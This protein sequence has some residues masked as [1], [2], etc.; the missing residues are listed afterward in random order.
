MHCKKNKERG[1]S[2]V[3]HS[4][5]RVQ[6]DGQQAVHND[7]DCP[8]EDTSQAVNLPA[9]WGEVAEIDHG[10]NHREHEHVHP[11]EAL[12]DLGQLSEEVG[13][14][15]FL[16][17]RTPAHI[18]R[19]HVRKDRQE[20]M[21][22]DTTEEDHEERHPLEVLEEGTE[23]RGFTNAVA[24]DSEADVGE[25]VEHDEQDDEDLP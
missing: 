1:C 4:Q 15:L 23:E 6:C 8:W 9:V 13:V 25:T 2:V 18:D 17:S 7:R 16:C 21:E 5:R 24:H 19:E 10:A 11:L 14:V 20:D 22:G 3:E 12:P